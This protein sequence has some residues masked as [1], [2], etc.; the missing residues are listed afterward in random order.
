MSESSLFVYVFII[1][2]LP[3]PQKL[4]KWFSLNN[5][6]FQHNLPGW[7]SA[8]PLSV[9]L[10]GASENKRLM[11]LQCEISANCKPFV[12]K[13]CVL[14]EDFFLY[15]KNADA[16]SCACYPSFMLSEITIQY[17]LTGELCVLCIKL[18]R[19]VLF[20]LIHGQIESNQIKK[21]VIQIVKRI[22]TKQIDMNNLTWL[23][24]MSQIMLNINESKW[25]NYLV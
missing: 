22:E 16:N 10:A 6:W 3:N 24:I 8:G 13:C 1:T 7:I 19:I 17:K 21:E 4:R 12:F 11:V 14:N 15:C 18:G 9:T 20:D 23:A 25:L 2:D 5:R